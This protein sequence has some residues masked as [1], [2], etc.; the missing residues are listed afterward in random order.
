MAIPSRVFGSGL[1][2]LSTISICGDGGTALTAAGTTAGDALQIVAVYNDVTTTGASAGVKLPQTEAGETVYITNGGANPLTVYPYDTNSTIN[3]TTSSEVLP[4]GV[5]LYMATSN[6]TW[7]SMQGYKQLPKKRYGSFYSDQTQ[8]AASVNVAYGITYTT[9]PLAYGV[10]IGSPASRIVVSDAG[11][12][13]FQFS[14]QVDATSGGDKDLYVWPRVNG[15][16]VPVSAS[17]FR[18]KG[19]DA[20]VVPSWNFLLQMNANDYF[21]LMWAVGS[22]DV[23]LLAL[24]AAP[25]VPAIPSVILSVNEVSL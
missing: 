11:I 6:T 4:S 18:I 3:G 20:E 9:A 22:T 14:L 15:T 2:Q 1:S 17:F 12:Y 13:D 5:S 24:A 19:N 10:A 16:D 8:T 23:Q 21:E 25:P 7:L